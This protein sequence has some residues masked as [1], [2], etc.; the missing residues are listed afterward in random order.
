MGVEKLDDRI[1]QARKLAERGNE[2]MTRRR[3]RF[4]EA[5]VA[6]ELHL[7]LRCVFGH[8]A[9]YGFSL[10]AHPAGGNRS[11]IAVQFKAR[12]TESQRVDFDSQQ[13]SMFACDVE[14]MEGVQ[15]VIPPFVR[16]QKFA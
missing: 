10:T 7:H 2:W 1:R 9:Q 14:G 11:V 15:E 12:D 3:P 6:A 8:Q 4:V 13:A 5:Y 16:F